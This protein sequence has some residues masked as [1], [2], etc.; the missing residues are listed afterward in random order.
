MQRLLE[1]APGALSWG[2]LIALFFFSWKF[3]LV[4]VI[5]IVLYDF[6]WLLRTVYFFFHLRFSFARMKKNLA[7]NWRERLEQSSLSWRQVNHMAVFTIYKEPYEVVR[8]SV[9]SLCETNFPLSQII[10]V[11]AIEERGGAKDRECVESI[12]KEF[13]AKFKK[14]LI[15]EH[16]AHIEGEVAGKASNEAWAV[17][18]AYERV[19]IP[20]QLSPKEI[21]VSVFDA[22]VHPTKDYFGILTYTYVTTPNPTHAG[23][24]PIVVFSNAYQVPLFAR[25]LGFSC[26]FWSMIQQARPEQLMTFSCYSIP[27]QALVDVKFWNT[28]V[29]A[30]DARIFYQCL[31]YYAGDWRVVPL[32]YPVTMEAVSG[33][34][35]MSAAANLY[36]QQ[37]RWAWGVENIP[38]VVK[39]F[40]KNKSFPWRKKIFWIFNIFDTFHSWAVSSLVIFL[41]GILP[42]LIGGIE[43]RATVASY[44]LPIITSTIMN[45][46]AL[47]LVSSA[48]MSILLLSPKIEFKNARWYHS[49]YYVLQWIFIPIAFIVFGAFP[50]LEAQTRLMWGGRLRLG[51]WSTPRSIIKST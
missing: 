12:I 16:P 25:L 21:L 48:F 46:S 44:N 40:V 39:E 45:I 9:K 20:L 8:E 5:G 33:N 30:E 6:L 11:L 15:T 51:Y 7:I 3:P 32:H 23:Y 34:S 29:I 22:D 41:A 28:N 27:L 36:K 17:R 10:L 2:T 19:V 50:A 1:I 43:F 14:V 4:V 38:Y 47:G 35:F 24:Q 26:S 49:G 31:N 42:N 18:E 13:G 37:R